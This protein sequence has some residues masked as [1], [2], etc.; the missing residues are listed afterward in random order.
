[1]CKVNKYIIILIYLVAD[2]IKK[3]RKNNIQC[4]GIALGPPGP[5]EVR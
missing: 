1:M 3:T 2:H 5:P 4:A